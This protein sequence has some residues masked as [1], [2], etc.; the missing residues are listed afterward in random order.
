MVP[1]MLLIGHIGKCAQTL[2]SIRGKLAIDRWQPTPADTGAAPP[3]ENA[4]AP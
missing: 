1:I 4:E 2:E 3:T